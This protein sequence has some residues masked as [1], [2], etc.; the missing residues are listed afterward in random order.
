MRAELL[1]GDRSWR[2]PPLIYFLILLATFVLGF[3][4]ALVH[5]KD[6]WATMPAGL[7]LSIVVALL[8]LVA[9]WLGYS[10]FRAGD[11]K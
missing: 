11:V 10:G 3:I 8:A 5:A 9:A 7:Y 4:N 1:R 2:G 6:V